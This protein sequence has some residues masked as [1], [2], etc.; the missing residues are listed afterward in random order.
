M[1]ARYDVGNL[2]AQRVGDP[3][4]AAQEISSNAQRR[5]V[6]FLE[7]QRR[8]GIGGREE[9]GELE[10][11]IDRLGDAQQRSAP[12]EGFEK[13]LERRADARD[14]AGHAHMLA[15]P[16]RNDCAEHGKPEEQ[17]RGEFVGPDDRMMEQARADADEQDDHLGHHQ[18]RRGDLDHQPQPALDIE[19]FDGRQ[20][21]RVTAGERAHASSPVTLSRTFQ[22]SAPNFSFHVL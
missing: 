9:R 14:D 8:A 21:L 11:R 19:H 2:D 12:F 1:D 4:P 18:Q 22:A 5:S 16:Q 3:G 20:G 13:G 15:P 10:R 7:Q 6:D 17:D